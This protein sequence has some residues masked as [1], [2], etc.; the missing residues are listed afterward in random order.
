MKRSKA[1]TLVELLVVVGII[2]LLV[3]I[4]MPSLSRAL[5]LARKAV[6]A[7]QLNS[8]G[9]GSLL[10]VQ[11]YNSY[12]PMGD[13]RFSPWGWSKFYGIM[14]VMGLQA[15]R[16]E[17]GIWDFSEWELDE[18]WEKAF[19]PAMD[20]VKIIKKADMALAGG[21]HPLVKVSYHRVAAGY[22]WNVTLRAAAKPMSEYP[23][24]RW[25]TALWAPYPG[26]GSWAYTGWSDYRLFLPGGSWYIAQAI[27]P[28]E[29]EKPPARVAEAWDGF[30]YEC[31]PNVTWPSGTSDRQG[32]CPGWHM[33]PQSY[34]TRGWA[35]MN[36]YRHPSSPN[37]LYADGHSAA[38]A[39]RELKPNQ[40]GSM[41]HNGSWM[42]MRLNSW[43]DY[44]KTWGTMHHIIPERGF[45]ST[46][47]N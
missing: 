32:L 30:D 5:A 17:R 19:C 4:L 40:M 13:N 21:D 20:Y 10:Y 2:A 8:F 9:K 27:H 3:T 35:V 22:Q 37:I 47:G 1:F 42:D 43:P 7:T 44:L 28:D 25:D 14:Q 31:L 16:K 24:G 46:N 26:W 34:Q 38:D 6:C 23:S 41:P 18:C 29:I 11:D 33:G 12:P 39:T 36:G 15:S 45:A